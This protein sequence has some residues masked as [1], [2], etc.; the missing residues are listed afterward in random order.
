M[1]RLL[2]S[3]AL[4]IL[5]A[6]PAG[7]QNAEPATADTADGLNQQDRD[8][9]AQAASGG[10]A[11]VEA[12]RLAEQQA[13]REP[14]KGF[15]RR[16]IAD[17]GKANEQLTALADAAKATAPKGPDKAHAVALTRLKKLGG[18]AFDRAYMRGQIQDHQQ[19]IVLFQ[20]E[21]DSGQNAKLKAFAT[22]TLPTIRRHL[23]MAQRIRTK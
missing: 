13:L 22:A 18:A 3:A 11:E 14:V 20:A 16:M 21:A 2:A 12:G 15:A 4:A 1:R 7:A 8:F 17:H 9:I 10:L 19:M 5:L 6:T 23:R